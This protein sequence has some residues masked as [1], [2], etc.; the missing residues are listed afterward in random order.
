MDCETGNKEVSTFLSWVKED[1][2]GFKTSVGEN[3]KQ[4]LKKIWCSLCAEHKSDIMDKL[5]EAVN[6]KC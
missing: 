6:C 4:F 2:F 1:A 3:G 5:E